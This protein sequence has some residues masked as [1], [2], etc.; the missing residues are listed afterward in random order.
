M[1]L[2][3]RNFFIYNSLNFGI[4][5]NSQ[6]AC[7][8]S[9]FERGGIGNAAAGDK[10][11]LFRVDYAALNFSIRNVSFGSPSPAAVGIDLN[12][13]SNSGGSPLYVEACEFELYDKATNTSGTALLTANDDSAGGA[14]V[15]VA[16][17]F[18][19]SNI[20]IK[21]KRIITSMGNYGSG[22]WTVDGIN[23]RV[24]SIGDIVTDHSKQGW[25]I[26]P[27]ALVT[28]ILLADAYLF[29]S[30]HAGPPSAAPTVPAGVVPLVFDTA[31][32]RLWVYNKAWKYTLFT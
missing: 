14:L 23:S 1:A 32:N 10:A 8:D 18:G 7:Q 17:N 21:G 19:G 4:Y 28:A 25:Q 12:Y 2:Q 15:L 6:N 9:V 5:I 11:S 13:P 3:V 26:S 24:F 27:A 31:N 29:I 20:R 22:A 16:N 30:T